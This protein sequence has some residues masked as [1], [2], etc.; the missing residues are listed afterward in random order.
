MALTFS[1]KVMIPIIT[2]LRKYNNWVL[3]LM[4]FYENIRNVIFKVLSSVVYCII[5][6]CLCADYR[7]C[8][9]TKLHV[10]NKIFRNTKYNDISIIG[11]P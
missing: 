5:N 11:I 10:P 7:C 4:M 9:K 1:Y 2:F 6:N 8:L 3:S